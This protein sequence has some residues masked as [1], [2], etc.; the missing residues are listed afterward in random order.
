MRW[1]RIVLVLVA[2]ALGASCSSVGTDR[3]GGSGRPVVLVL[4][5]NDESLDG[6][7]AVTR[8][9]DR[10]HEL[11]DGRLRVDVQSSWG[12]GYD[13]VRVVRA[14]GT[15]QADLGWA[16][17]RVMDEVGV[18]VFRP[19]HAPF[20][21]SSYAAQAAVVG[22][23]LAGELLAELEPLGVTGL[24]LAADQLRMPAAAARPL[25]T[26]ADFAGLVFRTAASGAQEGGLRALGAVPESGRGS[27]GRL[28]GVD[29]VETM[30]WT[31]AISGQ[32]G[33]MPYVTA[34]AAL[35]PR[36]LAIF[37]NTERL[38]GLT[39]Q[40]RGWLQEAGQDA[41]SWSTAHAQD[42]DAEQVQRVC[43]FGA[44]VATATAG[45]LAALRSAAQPVYDALRADARTAAVLTRVEALV[46]DAPASPPAVLPPGCTYRPGEEQ[47]RTR[48]VPALAGPGDPGSLPQ[49]VYRLI[50]TR[51]Q[52][53]DLGLSEAEA[54]FNAGV[55]TYTLRAGT[56]DYRQ[57]PAVPVRGGSTKTTCGG[58]YTVRG[59][60][61]SF[62]TTTTYA[63]GSCAP[64]T[65]SARWRTD[66]SMLTWDEV[67]VPDFGPI[68]SAR[69]WQRIDG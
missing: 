23:S 68:W 25:L 3:S 57:Q 12:G 55:F 18:D 10:V 7:P 2:C 50:V 43:R 21:V 38:S 51:Q 16:G 13:E 4:A 17:T 62:T 63:V 6:A 41:S 29:A 69:P 15:G 42:R 52:L 59:D 58:W 46:A 66:G 48:D 49:G 47:D 31:Y 35:W 8:F 32:Y 54:D 24:A 40:Q 67:S 33:P 26:P 53:L 30:W 44:R 37:T 20:L 11:S 34:N 5:N 65:W 36:S 28:E 64:P 39:E 56:W 14:V 22:D 1:R 61:A 9:V 19:L 60:T 45:Q 27:P